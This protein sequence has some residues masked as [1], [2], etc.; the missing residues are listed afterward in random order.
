MKLPALNYSAPMV[1]SARIGPIGQEPR[2]RNF[3][4]RRSGSGSFIKSSKSTTLNKL[5]AVEE[6]SADPSMLQGLG[7][8]PNSKGKHAPHGIW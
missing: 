2:T 8:P 7:L 4:D 5:G 6:V 3:S 1:D